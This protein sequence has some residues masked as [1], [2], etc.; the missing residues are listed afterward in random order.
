MFRQDE[1]GSP[2]GCREQEQYC[3]IG[4]DEQQKCTALNA[5]PS[6]ISDVFDLAGE[7]EEDWIDWVTSSTFNAL[8]RT[9]EP[10]AVLGTR[11]LLSRNKLNGPILG[12]LPGNQWQME[13]KH[14]HA[15]AMA[16]IQAKFVQTAVGFK[17]AKWESMVTHPNTTIQKE[18]CANQV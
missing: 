4:A 16:Y 18:L 13:I 7:T 9:G 11:V 17:D 1:P 6:A 14:L 8:R 10:I 5:Y 12:T 3:V 15:I 2:L